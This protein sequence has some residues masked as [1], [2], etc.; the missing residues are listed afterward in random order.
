MN[1]KFQ[2][3]PDDLANLSDERLQALIGQV[4]EV[5]EYDRR[6]HQIYY[7]QPASPGCT[8]I[9]EFAAGGV[10]HV[11]AGGG[12]RS[13]KTE[14]CVVHMTA[15]AT[16]VFPEHMHDTFMEWFR[17]PINMRTVMESLTT[18]LHPIFLPK[19]QYYTWTGLKPLGGRKGHW[20]WV[21]KK[22]LID[23]SWE[24]S[25]SEKLRT[26]KLNCFDPEDPDKILGQS[27]WQFMSFD[28]DP[29]DFASGTFD[30]MHHDEPPPYGI[31]RENEPRTWDVN[32]IHLLSMTWP[33]DPSIPVD[34]IYDEFYEKG[35]QGARKDPDYEWVNL[36]T[37]DNI[38]LDQEVVRER[39]RG[40][41]A[42]TAQ[43]RVFGQPLRFSNRVHPL[44]TDAPQTWC[45]GH[46]DICYPNEGKCPG[47]KDRACGSTD[48]VEF[49]HVGELDVYS[50]WPVVY[51][52]DPHPRKPH[53]FMWAMVTPDDDYY[54]VEEGLLAEDAEEV[55]IYSH[56]KEAELELNTV[57]R[58]VD[59]NM[60]RSPSGAQRELTWQDEFDLAGLPLELA[61][62]SAVGRKRV[63]QYLKP[64][65]HTWRPRIIIHPRCMHVISQ[66]KRYVWDDY[67]R[68]MERDQKQVP[69]DKDD[70]FPTLLK[71]LLNYQPT[72]NMLYGG[73]QV[74]RP[75]PSRKGIDHGRPT[76]D[77]EG[78]PSRRRYAGARASR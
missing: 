46:G 52:I 61:D 25:W 4:V 42:Q 66:M 54:V 32:G 23:G 62:D 16:G 77:R 51:L 68:N 19:L 30:I 35:I 36:I 69:K 10:R 17:G 18:V 11:G 39:V 29:S 27:L 47:T 64:D 63:N 73:G 78:S 53:M 70:D 24:K 38:H 56:E 28:Q 60:G 59:P 3:G 55:K 72:F 37:T 14:T 45:F 33:D 31:W 8:K 43:T 40:L 13:S 65:E 44:F 6:E 5:N 58:L 21:P 26:L 67:R 1:D 49:N 7:Y 9:H 74:I 2:V 50:G 48:I 71:Y 76:D 20:G 41:D 75:H 22:C 34:W 12:N 57:L 15:M